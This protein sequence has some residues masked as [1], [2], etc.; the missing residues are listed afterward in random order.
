MPI[1]AS[2]GAN[3]VGFSI[4]NNRES[5]LIAVNDSI[6]DVIVVPMFEPIMTPTAFF[7]CISPEFTK[8]TSIT[9]VDDE[10]CM[11]AVTPIPNSIASS[12]LSVALL[13]AR[14]SVPPES[15]SRPPLMHCIP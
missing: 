13:N 8:P 7:S 1:I 11:S 3:D 12:L 2:K 5:P 10:L 6:H 9:V 4:F 15:L 14:S